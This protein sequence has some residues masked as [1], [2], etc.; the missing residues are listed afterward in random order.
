ME[1]AEEQE[2]REQLKIV[3]SQ[4]EIL[5]RKK[6]ELEDELE[7][8]RLAPVRIELEGKYFKYRNSDKCY[9][10]IRNIILYSDDFIGFE[11]LSWRFDGE[12]YSIDTYSEGIDPYKLVEIS[13]GE[14]LNAFKI[15]NDHLIQVFF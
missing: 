6:Q 13:K 15:V 8:L 4:S 12:N 3:N 14:F 11:G 9:A 2:L 5:Y 10:Y 1:S 7:K